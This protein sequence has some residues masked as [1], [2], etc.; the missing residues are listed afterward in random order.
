[1]LLG[2]CKRA[3]DGRNEAADAHERAEGEQNDEY[4]G[5]DTG[6]AGDEVER[7]PRDGKHVEDGEQHGAAVERRQEDGRPLDVLPHEADADE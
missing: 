1:M 3:C 2:A 7:L 4:E 5:A 6:G